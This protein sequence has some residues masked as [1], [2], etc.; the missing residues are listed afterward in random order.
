MKFGEWKIG[1]NKYLTVQRPGRIMGAQ[2]KLVHIPELHT[3][4]IILSNVG[5]TDI[6]EFAYQI[7]KRIF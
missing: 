7:G 3:N 1:N 2:T 6:D 5:T 4:I